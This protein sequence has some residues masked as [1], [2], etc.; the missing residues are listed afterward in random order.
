MLRDVVCKYMCIYAF[1]TLPASS[2]YYICTKVFLITDKE[3]IYNR[4]VSAP[5]L[6]RKTSR[7]GLG[8]FLSS[9]SSSGNNPSTNNPV[10]ATSLHAPHCPFHHKKL[11]P[12]PP[13][14]IQF[15]ITLNSQKT[16]STSRSSLQHRSCKNTFSFPPT[17]TIANQPS[18]SS[19]SHLLAQHPNNFYNAQH[20]TNPSLSK[21][22][23]LACECGGASSNSGKSTSNK[24]Q[25]RFHS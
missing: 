21:H 25:G 15:Q 9:S 1:A 11:T 16:P 6:K 19:S 14:P 24:Q 17:S 5:I 22:K 7:F 13:N 18:S 20:Q 4:Q 10:V 8:Q 23:T 3:K 12:P 2:N